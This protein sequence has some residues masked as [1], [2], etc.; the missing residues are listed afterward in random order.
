M[1]DRIGYA[2]G[3]VLLVA[4]LNACSG[5][6]GFRM[7]QPQQSQQP[8]EPQAEQQAQPPRAPRSSDGNATPGRARGTEA[9]AEAMIQALIARGN[10]EQELG[11]AARDPAKMKDSTTDRYFREISKTNQDLLDSNVVS[12]KL[13]AMEW[14]QVTVRGDVAIATTYETW[15]TTF[16]DGRTDQSHDRNDYRLVRLNGAWKIDG[17]SHPDE[18]TPRG[19]NRQ[20]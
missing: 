9:T 10:F 11:L 4:V 16:S 14:G 15:A 6:L 3:L 19:G 12:I 8:A 1:K 17:N 13:L 20:V 2:F 18:S 5:S 7:Q